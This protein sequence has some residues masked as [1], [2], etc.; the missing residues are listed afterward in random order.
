MER[1]R[2][3][4]RSGSP[5]SIGSGRRRRGVSL[6]P[7]RIM[8]HRSDSGICNSRDPVLMESRV[9]VGNLPTDAMTKDEFYD[10]FQIYGKLLGILTELV[11]RCR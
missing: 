4:S 1:K 3:R 8:D 9:F 11:A 7:I 6:S 10:R 5:G 2:G